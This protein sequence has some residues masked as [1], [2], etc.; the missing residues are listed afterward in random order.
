MALNFFK[1]KYTYL[2]GQNNNGITFVDQHEIYGF[3]RFSYRN[4]QAISF[5]TRR[6]FFF[7]NIFY[8]PPLLLLKRTTILRCVLNN[9]DA[10]IFISRPTRRKKKIIIMKRKKPPFYLFS[11]GTTTG[12]LSSDETKTAFCR[13]PLRRQQKYYEY[14]QLYTIYLHCKYLPHYPNKTGFTFY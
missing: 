7:K 2:T 10:I 4:E 14:F 12:L 9:K 3:T 5:Q 13:S 6:H 1:N 8:T 11:P